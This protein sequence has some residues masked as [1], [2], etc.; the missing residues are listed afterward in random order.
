MA[1]SQTKR[2][3]FLG[4]TGGCAL[5]ALTHTILA[6]PSTQN[7]IPTS[8]YH[9][10]A[11]VRTPSKLTKL[12]LTQPGM[13]QQLIDS[14][15]TILSGD[16]RDKE[17]LKRLLT[18]PLP[19]QDADGAVV[20]I[21]ITSL[22]AAPKLQWSLLTPV[23]LDNPN[24]C[25][26][27]AEALIGALFELQGQQSQSQSRAKTELKPLLAFVSTT[28]ISS[29]VEDVPF[30]FRF[31][32]HV[33]LHVPHQDKKKM[34]DLYYNADVFRGV[35]GARASL[36]TGTGVISEELDEKVRVGKE[37]NGTVAVGYTLRRAEVGKWLFK[38]VLEADGMEWAGER[39][40]LTY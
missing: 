34:E 21:I 22:G 25:T 30:W 14:H 9:S 20:D 7:S 12:L 6:S 16:A 26:E 11:L 31:L 27:A 17:N 33:L 18:A 19:G 24:L 15:L 5:S 2:V 28:G 37:S 29:V 23:T 8:K 39:V 32:Y 38:E 36:L 1:P 4:A 3:A 40:T 35:V 13:T 10:Y